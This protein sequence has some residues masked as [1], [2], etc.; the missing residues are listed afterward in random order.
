MILIKRNISAPKIRRIQRSLSNSR[1]ALPSNKW[2]SSPNCGGKAAGV[3]E[4]PDGLV[5]DEG[6]GAGEG[7][8]VG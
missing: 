4:R 2:F 3:V 8:S 6:F 7:I 1:Q 5:F